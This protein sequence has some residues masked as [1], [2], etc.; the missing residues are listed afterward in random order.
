MS[1][2][3]AS[4]SI[5]VGNHILNLSSAAELTGKYGKYYK[6][7]VRGDMTT[8]QQEQAKCSP[9]NAFK[10]MMD[11]SRTASNSGQLASFY[12]ECLK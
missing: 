6:D 7:Y 10:I 12:C 1:R 4:N 5:T 9:V 8:T 3:E 11:A 2:S